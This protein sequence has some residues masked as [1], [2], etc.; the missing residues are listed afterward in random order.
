MRILKAILAAAIV[1]GLG[2]G[3]AAQSLG[4]LADK[5]KQKRQGKPAPKV[6]TENDLARAGKKGTL[7]MAGSPVGDA[8][9]ADGT[10]VADG[11]AAP[12]AEPGAEAAPEGTEPPAEAAPVAPAKAPEPVKPKGPPQKTE[13][14]VR[15]EARANL[16]KSLDTARTNLANHQRALTQ[17]EGVLNASAGDYSQS[18]ADLFKRQDEEKAAVAKYQDEITKLEE[19]VR[20]SAWPR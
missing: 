10:A 12:E 19:D 3:A 9:A 6:I 11:T 5:E 16:Q 7:S 13:E 17:I 2:G 20:R 15:S 14:E 18:R 4:Q 1:L 8:A